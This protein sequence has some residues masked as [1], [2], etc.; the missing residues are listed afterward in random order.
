MERSLSN[1]K[2][3]PVC[4]V[5]MERVTS[6]E[7]S[8]V[9]RCYSCWTEVVKPIPRDSE[10]RRIWSRELHRA[11]NRYKALLDCRAIAIEPSL[12]PNAN[13]PASVPTA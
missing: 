8:I 2:R 11:V 12:F 13:N 9:H 10:R 6:D 4:D 5:A 1:V 7:S 3:C